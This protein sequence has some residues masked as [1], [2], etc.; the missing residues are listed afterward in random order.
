[1]HNIIVDNSVKSQMIELCVVL[2]ELSRLVGFGISISIF[3]ILQGSQQ[4]Y[5]PGLFTRS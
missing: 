3:F 5:F 4:P 1:M 2:L